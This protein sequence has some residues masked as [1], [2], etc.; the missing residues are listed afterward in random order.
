MRLLTGCL[1]SHKQF[2]NREGIIY[3]AAMK[4]YRCRDDLKAADRVY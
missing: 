2:P 4:N 3:I 1:V